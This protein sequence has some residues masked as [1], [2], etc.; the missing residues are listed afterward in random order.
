M[1]H[2]L[3]HSF[4]N[5]FIDN[6]HGDRRISEYAPDGRTSETV[7]AMQ[8]TS[9][10]IKVGTA[11]ATLVK[12]GQPN[13][14]PSLRYRDFEDARAAERREHLLASNRRE[15]TYVSLEPNPILGLPFKPRTVATAYLDWPRLREIF[16]VSFPGIKTSRDPLLVDI[17]RARL[18][19]RMD[20]Y[21]D[22]GN[23]DEAVRLEM[24]I[25]MTSASRFDATETRRTLLQIEA[26][27]FEQAL[28]RNA[29]ATPQGVRRDLIDSRHNCPANDDVAAGKSHSC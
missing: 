15:E 12:N 8:G 24:P 10:G 2:H 28:E 22:A 23:T 21:L 3:L 11:I 17:D 20:Y 16:P 26:T 18:S 27:A 5:I 13:E 29:S 6:L 14:G 1:R 7:F 25:S 9:V 4:N 19:Q